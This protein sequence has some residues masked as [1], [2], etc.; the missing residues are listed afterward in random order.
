[1]RIW[2][3]YKNT[4]QSHEVLRDF[5]HRHNIKELSQSVGLSTQRLYKWGEPSPPNG[6]GSPNPLDRLATLIGA[7]GDKALLDWLCSKAGGY[8]VDNDSEA[9]S[10]TAEQLA[11]SCNE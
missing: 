7:T 2:G 11:L 10:D 4:M 3:H 5:L 1:M 8:F 6:S 9:M